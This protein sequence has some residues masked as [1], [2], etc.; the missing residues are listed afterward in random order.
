VPA[1]LHLIARATPF[2]GGGARQAILALDDANAILADPR[3][4]RICDGCGRVRDEEGEWHPLHRFLEDR[5]GLEGAGQLCESCEGRAP[6][7]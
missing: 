4:V 7:K 2:E 6:R 5:L 1:D 3:I